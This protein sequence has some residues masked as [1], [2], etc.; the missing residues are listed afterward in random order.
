MSGLF[1]LDLAGRTGFA[2][3]APGQP[4][5]V[6]GS[7]SLP[8]TGLNYGRY[9]AALDRFLNDHFTAHRPARVIYEAP[10]IRVRGGHSATSMHT[11]IKLMNLAG[12]TE[13]VCF[14]R[15]IPCFSVNHNTVMK[16]FV[17][18]G[19]LSRKA[20]KAR[21]LERCRDLGWDPDND[22][23]ADAMAIIDFACHEL[24]VPVPWSVG[25]LFRETAA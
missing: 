18:H 16:H 12:H 10:I 5:P 17:G 2:F 9:L 1:A 23:E 6:S 24:K 13:F 22:D 19:N 21:C 14:Q 4:R 11:A 8:E 3:W 15:E 25:G 20:G 7:F